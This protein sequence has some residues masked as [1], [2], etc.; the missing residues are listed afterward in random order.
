MKQY[1]QNRITQSRLLLPVMMGF[2]AA[3]WLLA[4]LVSQ[5]WWLQFACFLA[6]MYLIVQIN[7][8]NALIRIYSRIASYTFALL[9]C[10]GCFLFPSL[11]GGILE[12]SVCTTILFL[13]MTYQD[14]SAPG[15]TF[16]AFVILG[17]AALACPIILLYVPI[18]WLLMAINLQSLSWRTWG[19][20]LLGLLT[21]ALYAAIGHYAFGL[22]VTPHHV[23]SLS[24]ALFVPSP[25]TISSSS[26]TTA[27]A[28]HSAP[29]ILHLLL[30]II[31]FL[32][33]ITHTL[34]KLH[35]EKVRVRQLSMFFIWTALASAILAIL[36]PDHY[37]ELVRIF[38]ICL[39]PLVAHYIALTS[40]RITNI[41]FIAILIIT[42]GITIYN[43]WTF[44]FPF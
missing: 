11:S 33:S 43:L 20:S 4:G 19:A 7:N 39:S 10:A 13:F 1:L 42:F 2:V 26:L 28:S 23:G 18:L 16:Y 35:F 27:L 15:L 37:N 41:T 21:T 25:L 3:I 8:A 30:L 5:Q 32:I 17:I 12:V 34:R 22:D 6:S 36:Y 24:G 14:P 38:I 44:L 31:L 40:T 29:V 9:I